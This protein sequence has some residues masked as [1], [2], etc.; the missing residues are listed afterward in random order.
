MIA[1][2]VH[3]LSGD[4]I[5]VGINWLVEELIS[6]LYQTVVRFLL[7]LPIMFIYVDAKVG[8]VGNKNFRDI[9]SLERDATGPFARRHLP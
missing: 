2:E 3:F 1:L 8:N 5:R 9:T 6:R 7:L 4:Y